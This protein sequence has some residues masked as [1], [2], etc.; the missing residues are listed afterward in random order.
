MDTK[1][2]QEVIGRLL[3]YADKHNLHIDYYAGCAEPGYD[4]KPVIAANWNG[5][6]DHEYSRDYENTANKR[7]LTEQGKQK[8]RLARL[9]KWIEDEF[10]DHVALE[11]SDEWTSCDECGKAVR[12]SPNG[13]EWQAYYVQDPQYGDLACGDCVKKDPETY[14]QW[15]TNDDNR[16]IPSWLIKG[17]NAAGFDCA[18]NDEYFKDTCKRYETGL[19]LGMN[20]TPEKALASLHKV[21][22]KAWF[23][24][25]MDY[26]FAITE[27]SQFY[28]T[29]TV[30]VR[31]KYYDDDEARKANN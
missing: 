19:H 16:A 14:L 11:W 26:V 10:N 25:N 28:V 30:L 29:W 12:T 8:A 31:S 17:A 18:E 7:V 20:D 2:A 3:E 5:P 1:K 24:E 27:T 22:G 23:E 4:D 13:Y 15:F 9:G 21:F 6:Y